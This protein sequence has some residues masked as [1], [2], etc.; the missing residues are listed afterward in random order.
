MSQTGRQAKNQAQNAAGRAENSEALDWLAAAGLI[1]LGVVHVVVGWLAVQLA[2]GDREGSASSSGALK[3]LAEQPF[4]AI[5]VWLVALGMALLVVWQVVKV[6]AGHRDEEDDKKR[7]AKRAIS[8]GK[9]VVYAVIAFSAVQVATGSG[10]GGGGT[11]STTAKIMNLPGGQLIV[12]AVGLGIIAV[13]VALLVMA[14]KE[15]YLDRLDAEGRSGRTGT[16][17]RWLGRV[18]HV[19]KGIALGI[20][21]GL[22]LYAAVTHE[23]DK[24]GGLDQALTKV[25]DQPFGPVLLTLMGLGFAAYGVFCFAW[26]RHLDR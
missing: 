12:G 23:P 6:V 13:G 15:K 20:V 3:Q 5:L 26:A 22:F 16:I 25:L 19:A 11:D 24:S 14:W 21:G 9:A 10:G 17:Y 4:G 1:A 2:L 18:G 7:L 8:G